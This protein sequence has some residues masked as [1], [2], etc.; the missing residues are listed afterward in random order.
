MVKNPPA[1]AGDTRDIGSIPGWGKPPGEEHGNPLQY[2]C[3]K[4]PMDRGAWR[5][6]VHEVAKSWTRLSTY[7]INLN[8]AVIYSWLCQSGTQANFVGLTNKLDL[9]MCSWNGTCSY[10]GTYFIM[11][12]VSYCCSNKLSQTLW[13]KITLIYYLAVLGNRIPQWVS[14][15]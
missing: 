15:A 8:S 6:S 11:S 14:Q 2:S 3:L 12:L 1:N 7:I 10:A 5:A 9:R 4:N 13:L